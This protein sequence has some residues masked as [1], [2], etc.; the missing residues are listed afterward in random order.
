MPQVKRR[1]RGQDPLLLE[2][3]LVQAQGQAQEGQGDERHEGGDEAGL[4]DAVEA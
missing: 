3:P 1:G 4:D 2:S